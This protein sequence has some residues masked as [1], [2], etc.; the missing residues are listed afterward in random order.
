MRL[1]AHLDRF[2]GRLPTVLPAPETG[3]T[4]RVKEEAETEAQGG[5]VA[6]AGEEEQGVMEVQAGTTKA[7][8]WR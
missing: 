5:M 4:E 7:T 6:L 2:S 3:A 1:G 8:A